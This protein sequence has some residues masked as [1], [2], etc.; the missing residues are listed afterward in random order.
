MNG[1]KTAKPRDE[2]D[3]SA[4]QVVG[5]INVRER[6]V[7]P[8][9][10]F[11]AR[12]ADEKASALPITQQ[13]AGS[14]TANRQRWDAA[15]VTI[16]ADI[17]GAEGIIERRLIAWSSH[18]NANVGGL[19]YVQCTESADWRVDL[20]HQSRDTANEGTAAVGHRADYCKGA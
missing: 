2:R 5:N 20:N 15:F 1:H 14:H 3:H 19:G 4:E 10:D 16:G 18:P 6:F 7:P 17:P 8:G 12:A 9:I 13:I 11:T